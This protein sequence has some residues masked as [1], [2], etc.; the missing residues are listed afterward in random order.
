MFPIFNIAQAAHRRGTHRT[1]I[2]RSQ[3]RPRTRRRHTTL[4]FIRAYMKSTHHS[5]FSHLN[6]RRIHLLSLWQE[7]RIEQ[8]HS[9]FRFLAKM[10]YVWS[11]LAGRNVS[12]PLM[13]LSARISGRLTFGDFA[14]GL[15]GFL[16]GSVTPVPV[17]SAVSG[18]I[19]DVVLYRVR[20]YLFV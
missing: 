13:A 14:L 5:H 10:L 3:P 17:W 1:I 20:Q 9:G 11:G 19:F 7:P 8:P 15:P 16:A 4:F 6:S 18:L 12:I 2:V